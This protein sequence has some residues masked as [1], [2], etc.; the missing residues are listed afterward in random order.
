MVLLGGP[1]GLSYVLFTCP[2]AET[3]ADLVF[4]LDLFFCPTLPHSR[5]QR[6]FRSSTSLG[7]TASLPSS[8][9]RSRVY[10]KL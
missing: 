5:L 7:L 3:L 10:T 2:A 1:L 9:L 6:K 4:S 8:R